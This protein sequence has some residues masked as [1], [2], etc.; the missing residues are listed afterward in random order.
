V[1]RRKST[2][3]DI[4]RAQMKEEEDKKNSRWS[5]TIWVIYICLIVFIGAMGFLRMVGLLRRILWR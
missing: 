4:M 1:L 2:G 5:K 3:V